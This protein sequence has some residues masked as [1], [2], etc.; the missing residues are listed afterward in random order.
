MEASSFSSPSI[1]EKNTNLNEE[2]QYIKFP[3]SIN[4]CSI[5]NNHNKDVQVVKRIGSESSEAEVYHIKYKNKDAAL[6][7]MP[8]TSDNDI[9]KNNNEI[10]IANLAS[11]MV[12]S[13]QCENFPLVYGS[14]RCL[15]SKFYNNFWNDKSTD[16]ACMRKL[17]NILPAKNKQMD[18]LFRSGQAP[19]AIA[20]RFNVDISLCNNLDTPSNFLISELANMDLIVWSRSVHNVK[21]WTSIIIQCLSAILCMREKMKICHNDL[22]WGNILIKSIGNYDMALIH[23]FGRSIPIEPDNIRRDLIQFISSWSTYHYKMPKEIKAFFQYAEEAIQNRAD[24]PEILE[25]FD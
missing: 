15:N 7:I 8:I 5:V 6:K 14:G 11:D 17:R 2:R 1:W 16:Y 10:E 19:K 25:Y 24:I 3:S 4:F 20:E 22:H 9:E 18:A 23:D 21:E 12:L 13:N